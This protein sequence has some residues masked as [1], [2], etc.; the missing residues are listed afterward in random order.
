MRF[1]AEQGVE[2]WDVD[3][4]TYLEANVITTTAVKVAWVFCYI[5]VYGLRPVIVRPK[6]IG[7]SLAKPNLATPCCASATLVD[8]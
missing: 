7:E 8:V 2:G 6:K 4:P 3:L 5:L 1:V